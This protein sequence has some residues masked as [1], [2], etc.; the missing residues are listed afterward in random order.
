MMNIM[1]RQD[2]TQLNLGYRE[3]YP[4]LITRTKQTGFEKIDNLVS[5]FEK[6]LQQKFNGLPYRQTMDRSIPDL[7]KEIINNTLI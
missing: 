1:E 7:I 3:A 2:Q 5:E 4:N 6:F